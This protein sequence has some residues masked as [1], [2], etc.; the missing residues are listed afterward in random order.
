MCGIVG[1]EFNENVS[2][3]TIY[4]WVCNS[5]KIS[6]RRGMDSSGISFIVKT[7]NNFYEATSFKSENSIFQLLKHKKI[8]NFIKNNHNTAKKI[9]YVIGHTRMAT[10]G[11]TINKNNQPIINEKN[12][13][14][15][16]F[17]GIITN[18]E[19]L[20]K[21]YKIKKNSLNDGLALSILDKDNK[22]KK[23]IKGAYS[24]IKI[25]YDKF[26]IFSYM[27]NNGS[28]YISNNSNKDLKKIILSESSFFK[29]LNINSFKQA[30][31]NHLY[32]FKNKKISKNIKFKTYDILQSN[33]LVNVFD[34]EK[35]NV[36]KFLKKEIDKRSQ[37][38]F[39]KIY[40]CKKCILPQTH[41]FIFFDKEGICNFCRSYNKK[42][43]L[44]KNKLKN[45]IN[46]VKNK[47]GQ[48]S[49][50]S[51]ISG[52]RDSCYALHILCNEFNIRPVT[53]TYD[54]GLNTDIAR[55]NV[56]IMTG[57]L[58]VE[59]ILI[60]AD[61]RKKRENVRK[62]IIAWLK[63]P[64]LGTVPLFMAGDKQFISNVS[65]LKKELN[66][67]LEIFASNNHEI[68][69]FKE[70]FSNLKL[71]PDQSSHMPNKMKFVSQ[72]KLISFYAF[73]FLKN[74]A[75]LNSSMLDSLIGFF[76]YYH[77]GTNEV[78]IFDYIEW[79]ENKINQTLTK[80]YGWETAIDT[81]GTWR[82]GDGTAAFYNFIYFVYAGFTE[83]DVLR[84]NLI[85]DGQLKRDKALKLV[86]LEN[87]VRLPTLEWY[88]KLLNLD[89]KKTLNYI[90]KSS[91]KYNKLSF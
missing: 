3:N 48:N 6:A 32:S 27:T 87:E 62:N 7:E 85:R 45:M 90:I 40:R 86:N 74:P 43:I 61:I 63:K 78:Q 57:E 17:N 4:K 23:Y 34:V 73:Q 22:R 39:E 15:F 42:N 69:Q 71:W 51:S 89:M 18:S 91:W 13:N 81:P 36:N 12:K 38:L 28:L 84:S 1:L 11:N 49:I 55:R 9:N 60:S 52:G 20:I 76:N 80:K 37:Y 31:I 24:F 82:I 67:K 65:I 5:L 79:N 35:N 30:E 56:S 2:V 50:L 75:Y 66:S 19:N 53:Y 14:L 21:K 77:S 33:K 72:L 25:S 26:L 88:F 70:E 59:N 10:N 8:K 47:H 68:T 29:K 46:L 41:P 58:N 54:W 16:V 83:N 44:S 64:H